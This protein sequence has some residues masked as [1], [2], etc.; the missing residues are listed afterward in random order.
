VASC[1]GGNVDEKVDISLKPFIRNV[2]NL[3]DFLKASIHGDQ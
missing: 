1:C 2:H 3:I